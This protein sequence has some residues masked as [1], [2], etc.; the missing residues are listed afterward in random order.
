MDS[1]DDILAAK[2]WREPPEIKAIKKYVRE[3]FASEVGVRLGD[4]QIIIS[5]SSSVLASAIRS[6]SAALAKAANTDKKLVIRIG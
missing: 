1:L 5:A 6:N 3:N 2:D 4:E